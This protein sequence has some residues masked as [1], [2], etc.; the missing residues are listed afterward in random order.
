MVRGLHSRCLTGLA[1]VITTITTV[2]AALESQGQSKLA[3]PELKVLANSM[4]Y[5]VHQINC[6]HIYL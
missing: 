2:S 4:T 1:G 5:L 6:L 3:S